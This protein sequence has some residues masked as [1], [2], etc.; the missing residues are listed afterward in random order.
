MSYQDQLRHPN[1]QRKRLLIFDR[2]KWK[3]TRCN[4][5][6]SQLHA[7]HKQYHKGR[8]PWEYLDSDIVTLCEHCH[9]GI[10]AL[11][12]FCGVVIPWVHSDKSNQAFEIYYWTGVYLRKDNDNMDDIWECENK[13][14]E[15]ISFQGGQAELFIKPQSII[16][17]GFFIWAQECQSKVIEDCASR[18]Q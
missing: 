4:G 1:W 15:R 16:G 13:M 7:H 3:C 5:T 12:R 6:E 17:E 11:D 2:D 8:K 14:G 10:H 18:N 9:S